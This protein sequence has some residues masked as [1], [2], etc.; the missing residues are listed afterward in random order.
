MESEK[1]FRR[2]PP[3]IHK[4]EGGG[5]IR[6]IFDDYTKV[7]DLPLKGEDGKIR[8]LLGMRKQRPMGRLFTVSV[9]SIME[10]EEFF[11]GET[12]EN[13]EETILE[14]TEDMADAPENYTDAEEKFS[15]TE[16]DTLVTETEEDDLVTETEENHIVEEPEK[17]KPKGFVE[18]FN[19]YLESMFS[20]HEEQ[21]EEIE[22]ELSAMFSLLWKILSGTMG[23]IAIFVIATKYPVYL[24]TL[25]ENQLWFSNIKEVEREISFRTEQGLYY[26]YYKQILDAPTIAVGYDQLKV[27]NKTEN[28]RTINIFH[29]FNILPEVVLSAV[30]RWLTL[31]VS[32]IIFYVW[33]VFGLHGVFLAGLYITSWYLSG[34]ILGGALTA[35][36]YVAHR[37]DTTRVNYTIPLRESFA[38]PLL[39]LQI[40]IICTFLRSTKW[41]IVKL[42]TILLLT[43]SFLLSWQF[44]PFVL[45]CQLICMV[46]L[47]RLHLLPQEKVQRLILAIGTSLLVSSFVQGHPPMIISSPVLSMIIPAFTVSLSP[48]YGKNRGLVSK[49]AIAVAEVFVM[50]MVTL[51]INVFVKDFLHIDADSHVYQLLLAKLQMG[52]PRNFDSR[53][54]M[55]NE[56][57][58]YLDVET[59]GRLTESGL[60]PLYCF[61]VL[62]YGFSML[63]FIAKPKNVTENQSSPHSSSSCSDKEKTQNEDQKQFRSQEDNCMMRKQENIETLNLEKSQEFQNLL[64][65]QKNGISGNLSNA[66]NGDVRRESS[67]NHCS[68]EESKGIISDRPDIAFF[69]GLSIVM[70]ILALLILRLKVLW[71]PMVCVLSGVIASDMQL[72]NAVF[73]SSGKLSSS[74][75]SWLPEYSKMGVCFG[76]IAFLVQKY[77]SQ[78]SAE[79]WPEEMYEFWDPDTVELMEWIQSYTPPTAVFAGSMQLLA[80]VKLCTNRH[81]TNHPHYEDGWLRNRTHQVY[82]IYGRS[83]P[84]VVHS[85]LKAVG[86]THIILE[87][88]I[89]MAPPNTKHPL[90]RL[91]DIVDL[92]YGHVPEDGQINI[93]GLK[94]PQYGRFCDIIRYNTPHYSRLFSLVMNNKTFRVYRVAST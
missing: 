74:L 17:T 15:E 5:D 9:E 50:L 25:H 77:W 87:D 47:C 36:F 94:V 27:D 42:A 34:S 67:L 24:H 22:E 93:P 33:T 85:V 16:E 26:S 88:S 62:I 65:T 86:A 31:Q 58:H 39:F 37:V 63:S 14:E 53:L 78:V 40:L 29:R 55:C 43:L 48:L 44:G 51:L 3:N 35:I 89:C 80:G 32:P 64:H 21:D 90:C 8:T 68:E 41:Q 10:A 38:V 83:S 60:L 76:L 54:Y 82:Q 28:G 52:D 81:I 91:T 18:T 13:K 61:C 57:F 2:E 7:K 71:L 72:Y 46:A 73:R 84:E 56:A 30:H 11:R 66:L 49:V 6:K 20:T 70:G 4:E 75:P 92:H 79:L 12:Q 19:D 69:L 1:L 23:L 45:L 59:L